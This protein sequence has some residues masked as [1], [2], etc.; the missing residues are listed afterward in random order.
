VTKARITVRRQ[1]AAD[2]PET[3]RW[4]TFALELDAQA[5]LADALIA[6][7]ESPV[8]ESSETVAP[9]AFQGACAGDRCGACVV[10]VNGHARPACRTRLA[11]ML[12]R[13]RVK[14]EPLAKLPLIR[15]LWVD[16]RAVSE[17]FA[18]IGA[19]LSDSALAGAPPRKLAAI[20]RCSEC[21]ACLEACPEWSTASPF[22]GPA[23]LNEARLLRALGA[24]GEVL[25][26]QVMADGGVAS[27]AKAQN[28]SVVCPEGMPLFDSILSLQ[29]DAT[30]RWLKTLLRR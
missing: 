25:L 15:D 24:N 30:R 21:G 5:T 10:L 22:V 11:P 3:Q 27:C 16:T 4:E 6:I 18:R 7:R 9:V 20:D 8:T 2:R 23:A 26:R 28:C 13:G 29:R 1:D 17:S 14:L 12:V 19:L